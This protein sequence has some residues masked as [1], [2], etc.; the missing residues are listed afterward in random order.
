MTQSIQLQAPAPESL[1]LQQSK[2]QRDVKITLVAMAAIASFASILLLPWPISLPISVVLMAGALTYGTDNYPRIAHSSTV[3]IEPQPAP[4]AI[5]H[6][7]PVY[8]M[9]PTTIFAP[10]HHRYV[11][12]VHAPVGTSEIM[13]IVPPRCPERPR[14]PVGTGMLTRV[15]PSP[16]Y[17]HTDP[18]AAPYSDQHTW[19]QK[20]VP[21]GRR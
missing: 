10:R 19:A 7:E 8:Y 20:H 9:P 12:S 15:E 18:I 21:V 13:P 3:F 16:H 11:P 6:P 1:I 4:V 17:R 5:L 2:N 14:V